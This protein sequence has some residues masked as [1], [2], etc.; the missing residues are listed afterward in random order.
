TWAEDCDVCLI[1]VEPRL[2]VLDRV[3][4]L[5]AGEAVGAL[6]SAASLPGSGGLADGARGDIPAAPT[7]AI[8]G[9]GALE[10]AELDVLLTAAQPRNQYRR[11]AS[12]GTGGRRTPPGPGR[13][14]LAGTHPQAPGRRAR[15][16]PRRPSPRCHL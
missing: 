14:H 11:A 9:P 1:G 2:A 6:L 4:I 13:D 5:D 3:R 12:L 7:I 16:L 15:L 10:P 8:V